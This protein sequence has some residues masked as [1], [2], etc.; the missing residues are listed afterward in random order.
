[1]VVSTRTSRSTL[2]SRKKINISPLGNCWHLS[3]AVRPDTL[4]YYVAKT[5]QFIKRIYYC[6]AYTHTVGCNMT[7]N[8]L[9]RI[10]RRYSV[11]S[12]ILLYMC[13]VYCVYTIF[14]SLGRHARNLRRIKGRRHYT[15]PISIDR[16]RPLKFWYYNIAYTDVYYGYCVLYHIILDK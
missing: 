14:A 13:N 7:C 8:S 4:T 11:M 15:A 2:S 10:T 9:T 5:R 12:I 16:G 6:N 3:G 1:M